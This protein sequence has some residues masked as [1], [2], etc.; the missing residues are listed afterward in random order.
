MKSRKIN[1]QSTPLDDYLRRQGIRSPEFAELL[2]RIR[3]HARSPDAALVRHWRCG[4]KMPSHD[5]RLFIE[6]ATGGQ[7]GLLSWG[8]SATLGNRAKTGVGGKKAC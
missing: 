4:S 5:M 2:R 1:A 7:V 3:R 6:I 8:T